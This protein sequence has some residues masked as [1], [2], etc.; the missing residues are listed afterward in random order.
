LIK[1]A[2]VIDTIESPTA[3]T[4]KQLLLLIRKLDRAQFEPYLCVLRT[5][6]WLENEFRECKLFRV[7]FFSFKNLKSYFRLLHFAVFLKRRKID[8]VQTFFKDGN[9]VG[10]ISGK[11]GGVKRIVS[12]RRN[13]GYWHTKSELLILYRLNRMVTHFLTNS[14]NTKKWAIKTEKIHNR[15]ITV[16]PNALECELYY[17]A[18][19]AQRISFREQLGFSKNAIL[20]GAVA[21]LR[22]V[23][24]IDVLIRAANIVVRCY[25]RAGF[26][27]VGE[28]SERTALEQM[29]RTLEIDGSVRF[30]GEC[31]DIT[32]VLSCLDIGTLTSSSESFSNAIIEYMAASLAVVCSDVGGVREAIEDGVNGFVVEPGNYQQVAARI[33][34]LIETDSFADMGKTG[35]EKAVRLYS[36]EHV[37][38][39]Y[40]RFYHKA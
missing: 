18:T 23:K 29:C 31:T 9:K 27:I 35:R 15:K 21:N 39:L 3:G 16:I 28:G 17:R 33:M 1:I 2:F 4:E 30:L 40:H 26:V 7:N 12:T 24:S 36:S 38:D 20:I 19:D 25:P 37:I 6:K 13:Q 8:I 22:P 5:S 14:H 10:V 32:H 11:L 34:T